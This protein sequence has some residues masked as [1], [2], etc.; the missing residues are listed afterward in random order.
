M[1]DKKIDFDINFKKIYFNKYITEQDQLLFLENEQYIYDFIIKV[2][3]N[4]NINYITDLYSINKD[5]IQIRLK[6]RDLYLFKNTDDTIYSSKRINY[7]YFI[8]KKKI[9]V[10]IEDINYN[11]YCI[12]YLHD[13]YSFDDFSQIKYTCI[14]IYFDVNRKSFDYNTQYEMIFTIENSLSTHKNDIYLYN[15]LI[16]SVYNLKRVC[17]QYIEIPSEYQKSY[18]KLFN[19]LQEKKLIH[20][21]V[22]WKKRYFLR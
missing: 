22:F 8:Y 9:N 1:I 6:K 3:N 15:S 2:K 5:H 21:P 11:I 4:L 18:Y 16:Y 10:I 12:Y 14:Y 7:I 17:N 13:N 20:Y 19:L